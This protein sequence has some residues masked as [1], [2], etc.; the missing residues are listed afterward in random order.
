MLSEPESRRRD[1]NFV[2]SAAPDIPAS[3]VRMR[4]MD[5]RITSELA[6]A[7][8]H[9]VL[10]EPWSY[11]VTGLQAIYRGGSQADDSLELT[12]E[13]NA[14]SV[15]LRFE[16]LQDLEIESGFPYSYM[17]LEILDVSYLQRPGIGVRVEHYEPHPGIRFWARA[18]SVVSDP[19]RE[20]GG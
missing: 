20:S 15:T 7:P 17:G 1:L 14:T 13:R 5:Q 12:L 16:G 2:R 9:S 6:G 3:A 8:D 11:T 10:P 4:G 18:V 19:G